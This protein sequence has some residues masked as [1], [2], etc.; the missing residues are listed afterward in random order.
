MSGKTSFDRVNLTRQLITGLEQI[1]RST[2]LTLDQTQIDQLISYLAMLSKWNQVYNLTAIRDVEQMI[3]QH[4]LDSLVALSAFAGAKRVLD[5]GAGGGLPGIVLAIWA[6]KAEPTMH[7]TLLDT[8]RKKTA[9][10]TQVKVELNLGNVEI[11]N[12][13]VEQWHSPQLF[14]V[15]TARAFA[16]L[17]NLISW[18]AHLLADHGRFLALKGLLPE[19]EIAQLPP[20]WCV[21]QLSEL[22]VPGLNAQRH[23][24]VI[25]RTK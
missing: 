10:L 6:A 4:L 13:R 19:A 8:V 2:G 24:V 18:S 12:G 17:A 14:D 23:L 16:E 22:Q 9:F 15:I 7:I 21:A 3:T 11:V 25:E 5:V 1:Q 20:G